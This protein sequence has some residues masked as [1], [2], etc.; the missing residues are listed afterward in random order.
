MAGMRTVPCVKLAKVVIVICDS[1]QTID[2]M[3][4]MEKD[5]F[6]PYIAGDLGTTTDDVEKLQKKMAEFVPTAKVIVM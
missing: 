2:W 5:P 3:M 1:R 6:L 4:E